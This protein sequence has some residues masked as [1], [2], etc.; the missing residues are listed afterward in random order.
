M[1][2]CRV[3]VVLTSFFFD[4]AAT[5]AL[6]VV[7]H[8]KSMGVL[9]VTVENFGYEF[10]SEEERA[11]RLGRVLMRVQ[12]HIANVEL[13]ELIQAVTAMMAVIALPLSPASGSK[14]LIEAQVDGILLR[15]TGLMQLAPNDRLGRS[16]VVRQ[17]LRPGDGQKL[18]KKQST[19][20]LSKDSGKDS[21]FT[22]LS[23]QS[24]RDVDLQLDKEMKLYMNL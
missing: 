2:G 12:A 5:L 9:G 4:D 6:I 14:R 1:R 17:T 10:L 16:S 18:M 13:K 3:L 22:D 15:L 23:V 8:R 7:A 24:S 20:N 21:N 11:K 19:G